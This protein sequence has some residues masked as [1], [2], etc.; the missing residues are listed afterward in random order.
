MDSG[1]IQN[2][3]LGS[4]KLVTCKQWVSIGNLVTASPHAKFVG[5]TIDE[6]LNWN[7]H[8]SGVSIKVCT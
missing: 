2:L 7:E 6:N 4:Q 5:V 8:I 1:F 3:F